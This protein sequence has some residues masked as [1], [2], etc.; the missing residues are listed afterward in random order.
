MKTNITD[1]RK[2]VVQI[3][4]ETDDP[5]LVK[6]MLFKMIDNVAQLNDELEVQIAYFSQQEANLKGM[7]K[8]LRESQLEALTEL[9]ETANL[10]EH[11][12]LEVLGVFKEYVS[13]QGY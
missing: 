4:K 12:A 13:K 7:L 11:E 10:S 9:T 1:L 5:E 2:S 8:N 6:D 3:L